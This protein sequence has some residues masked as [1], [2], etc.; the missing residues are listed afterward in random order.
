MLSFKM[1]LADK[2]SLLESVRK[3]EINHP[4][5][6]E[7]GLNLDTIKCRL[8]VKT[9]KIFTF[10]LNVMYVLVFLHISLLR[11]LALVRLALFWQF[12]H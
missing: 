2:D 3:N 8:P 10:C 9:V 5:D 6:L 1:E 7:Q 4:K 11:S 12:N